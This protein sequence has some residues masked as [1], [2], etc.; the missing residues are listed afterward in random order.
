[1][2][3]RTILTAASGGTASD[4]AIE[5][6]CRL[7]LRFGAH[8]EG[9]HVRIDPRDVLAMAGGGFGMPL[10]GEWIDQIIS[11]AADLASKT[12]TAFN[13][14]MVRHGLP[15]AAAP[16]ST[17]S[18]AWRED[19]GYAPFLVSRRARFFDLVILGRSDRVVEQPHS[20]TVEET[21]LHS[22]RPVLFA[23]AQAPATIGETIA[24]GW[25]GS[26]QAVRA[27]TGSLPLLAAARAVSIITV[28]EKDEAVT[29]LI[30]YLAWQGVRA[31]HNAVPFI[32]GVGPG[33]Q[34]LAAAREA[35]ADLL[36]MGGYGHGPWREFLFGGATREIVGV[37]ML[38][39]LLSH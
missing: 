20:D 21:L 31:T 2:S 7:A 33:Q 3:L 30:D 6:A 16:K 22:G 35:E 34:L 23:P 17:A 39:L 12:K 8:L 28:G 24:V 37:S 26:T 25:N 27:L 36:V 15:L 18:A 14:A 4:G 5:L 1:M 11:D 19:T 32:A 38:P 9:Y 13:A 29:S 10:A